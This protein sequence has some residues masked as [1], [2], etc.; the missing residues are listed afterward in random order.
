MTDLVFNTLLAIAAMC[1]Q[2]ASSLFP[3]GGPTHYE[4]GFEQCV[5]IQREVSKEQERRLD[6][7]NAAQNAKDRARLANALAA[8]HGKK[9]TPESAPPPMPETFGCIVPT[10]STFVSH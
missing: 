6:A 1:N 8:L 4:K 3:L 10:Q 7:E 9:F 2:H 5:V